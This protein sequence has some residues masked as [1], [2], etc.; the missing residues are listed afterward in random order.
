MDIKGAT[1]PQSSKIYVQGKMFPEIR[2]G[3]IPADFT[4]TPLQK[5]T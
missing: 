5:L 1:F 4:A 2:V 3:M